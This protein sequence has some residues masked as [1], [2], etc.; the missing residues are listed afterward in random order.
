MKKKIFVLFSILIFIVTLFAVSVSAAN[1][2]SGTCANGMTW[3]IN[4]SG[5][6]KITGTGDM[7]NYGSDVDTVAPWRTYYSSINNIVISTGITHIG[8]YAFSYLPNLTKVTFSSTITSIGNYAF[9]DC[10]SL[11]T[12]KFPEG[13]TSIGSCAFYDCDALTEITIPKSV[14][15]FGGGSSFAW[16]SGLKK[17]TLLTDAPLSYNTFAYCDKLER[18]DASEGVR[19]SKSGAFDYCKSLKNI[20]ISSKQMVINSNTFAGCAALEYVIFLG[21]NSGYSDLSKIETYAF[22]GCDALKK[23]YYTGSKQ[24]WNSITKESKGNEKFLS[25]TVVY[26]GTLFFNIGSSDSG[27]M[28]SLSAKVGSSVTFPENGFTKEGGIFEGWLYENKIYKPGDSIVMPEYTGKYNPVYPVWHSDRVCGDNLISTFS[29]DGTLTISGTGYMYDYEYLDDVVPAAWWRWL[30]VKKVVID[31]GVK[32]I[33]KNAFRNMSGITGVVVSDSVQ[34]IGEYA[35]SYC[36]DLKEITIG[37]DM[38]SIGNYAFASATALEKINWN[39]DSVSDFASDN[40]IFDYAGQNGNGIDVVFGVNARI[41]N[42]MFF[43]VKDNYE[44]YLPFVKSVDWGSVERIGGAAFRGNKQFTELV[45]PDSVTE[46]GISAFAN[47]SNIKELTLPKNVT[48]IGNSAFYGLTLLEKFYWNS[49]DVADFEYENTVFYR[50]GRDTE[51]GVEIVFGNEAKTLPAYAFMSGSYYPSTPKFKSLDLGVVERIG[52]GAFIYCNTLTSLEMPST[53]KKIEGYAFNSS[54]ISEIHINDLASWCKIEFE[55]KE[56]SVFRRGDGSLISDVDLYVNGEKITKLVIPVGV[57]SISDGAF[58]YCDTIESLVLKGT[59]KTVGKEAFYSCKRLK[60]VN[61]GSGLA[62]LGDHAFWGCKALERVT[63]GTG[64][65]KIGS[66]AFVNAAALKTVTIPEGLEEVGEFAFRNCSSITNITLP[67][68]LKNVGHSAF[69][70][71]GVSGE[72]IFENPVTV[73]E[74]AFSESKITSVA[75]G[76]NEA[77]I[78]KNAFSKCTELVSLTVGKNVTS[79]GLNAFDGCTSLNNIA[80]NSKHIT[81]LGATNKI[82]S[83]IDA[84]KKGIEITFGEGVTKIPD[85][86]FYGASDN[87]FKIASLTLPSTLTEIGNAAFSYCNIDGDVKLGNKVTKIGGNAFYANRINGILTIP[88]SVT[89]IGSYAFNNATISKVNWNVPSIAPPVDYLSVWFENAVIGK[90]VFGNTVTDIP[91]NLLL[92]A[93]KITNLTIGKSVK[94]IGED[95]FC[96]IERLDEIYWN[97]PEIDSVESSV[98]YNTG[99]ALELTCGEGITAFPANLFNGSKISNITLPSSITEIKEGTFRGC[100]NLTEIV[101][102]DNITHIGKNAFY[103]CSKLVK[104]TM[105]NNV[106]TVEAGAFYNCENIEGVYADSLENWCKINFGSSDSNPVKYAKKLYIDNMLV[107]GK[108]VIP[109]GVAYVGDYAFYN[110]DLV[111]GVKIP[112]SV[113]KI[114]TNAFSYNEELTEIDL[115]KGLTEIGTSAFYETSVK[116]VVIPANVKIVGDRVFSNCKALDNVEFLNK[117]FSGGSSM[118][119][120]CTAIKEI[121]L[122]EDLETISGMFNGCTSLEKVTF[123]KKLKKLGDQAF[124][125]CT[126]LDEVTIPDTVTEIW[127][128][129]FSG[130]T[131]LKKVKISENAKF[132]YPYAFYECTW[133]EEIVIPDSVETIGNAVFSGCTGLKKVTLSKN[134]KGSGLDSLFYGCSSLTEIE[135][136]DGVENI[137][138]SCFRDCTSLTNAVLGSGIKTIEAYAFANCLNLKTITIKS[139]LK[140]V[141]DYAFSGCERLSDVY[142]MGDS[143]SSVSIKSGNTDLLTATIHY[144]TTINFDGNGASEGNVPAIITS[145]GSVVTIP[146]NGFYRMNYEFKGWTDGTTIYQPG[147]SYTVKGN[148]TL[149]ALWQKVAIEGSMNRVLLDYDGYYRYYVDDVVQTK[150][151]VANNGYKYYFST[152]STKYGAAMVGTNVKIG[153]DY[154]DFD[155]EGRLIED[156]DSNGDPILYYDESK[157]VR[158]T[159]AY[160]LNGGDTL[161]GEKTVKV[162]PGDEADLTVKADKKGYI[163]RGWSLNKYASIPMDWDVFVK[164]NTVF[165]AVFTRN[166]KWKVVLEDDGYYRYYIDNWKQTGWQITPDGY[167]YYFSTSV[168]KYGAAMTGKG[169]KIGGKYY[170]FTNDGKLIDHYDSNGNPVLFRSRNGFFTESGITRYYVDDEYLIG[171]QYIDGNKYYFSKSNG[172]MLSGMQKIGSIYYN[173]G[174]DGAWVG[175]SRVGYTEEECPASPLMNKDDDGEYRYYVDGEPYTGWKVLIGEDGYYK[176]YFSKAD[177][178]AKTD[179]AIQVGSQVYDFTASGALITVEKDENGE[180]KMEIYKLSFEQGAKNGLTLDDDGEYRFYIDGEFQSGWIVVNGSKYLFRQAD[181]SAITSDDHQS[182]VGYR[183]G[184]FNYLFDSKGKLLKRTPR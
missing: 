77:T 16:C 176:Y 163:F 25:A 110:C 67:K 86:I 24:G 144:A 22:S 97:A 102:P 59:V 171:W 76:D 99:G 93:D 79:V 103:N 57:T 147:D 72:L 139:N 125:G 178:A 138:H 11:A 17:V 134:L 165:Y 170:D 162:Y 150:W 70:N 135:I 98:F 172:R 131:G 173:L 181:G 32:S 175:Y 94:T 105:G 33:G 12:V 49:V 158:I 153:A 148:V 20:T 23:I 107:T 18:V 38:C 123:P 63:F 54:S 35:F 87:K 55:S 10:K 41:P 152:S 143:W 128:S 61:T 122:P 111:T 4:D 126:A 116:S 104:V 120:G 58:A 64:I 27:T 169:V 15:S 75:F 30:D 19:F 95:A 124:S 62:E 96:N 66:Y 7:E 141:Y 159:V 78:G 80:W 48:K 88:A 164:E 74:S 40:H 52:K 127:N 68:T 157:D 73:G 21:N 53:L 108:L 177:G 156:Y 146:E 69:S 46:I 149:S 145:V 114:G 151:Q 109:D 13:L 14:T 100:G 182:S 121:I 90:F 154:Y 65:R 47:C 37:Y 112:D 85:Y 113:T 184:S 31:D 60:D 5:T 83:G 179:Y 140:N 117:T 84:E 34:I 92:K 89:H 136:P 167:K 133:L 106:K 82:F 183:Y 174:T 42:N 6:L 155:S 142:F 56:A 137:S 26:R 29:D 45:L 119:S 130:C 39:T 28:K 36:N 166:T 1:I 43:P 132:I 50:A 51:E 9:E 3:Y 180:A 160:N 101:I 129:V 91:E 2:A 44:E 118:F 115:G 71:C 8:D 168:T 81:K 161:Y